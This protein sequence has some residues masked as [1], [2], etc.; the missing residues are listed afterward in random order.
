M[1]QGKT[2][3]KISEQGQLTGVCAGLAEYI[4]MDVS[5]VRILFA[6]ISLFTGLPLILYIV[7]AVVLPDKKDVVDS[8]DP[9]EDEDIFDL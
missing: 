2:L 4:N 9:V 6:I 1:E 7:F 5:T 3:Y 8:E